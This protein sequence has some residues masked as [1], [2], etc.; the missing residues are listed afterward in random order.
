MASLKIL[1]V[2]DQASTRTLMAEILQELGHSN[3]S[4]A[5][6]GHAGLIVLNQ[7]SDSSR[8]FSLIFI[9]IHMPIMGGIELLKELRNQPIYEKTP[10]IMVTTESE[11]ELILDAIRLKANDYIVKPFNREILEQKIKNVFSNLQE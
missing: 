5:K 11:R 3:I 10:V 6:N 1:I 4:E 8:P 7:A 9:D 2:D